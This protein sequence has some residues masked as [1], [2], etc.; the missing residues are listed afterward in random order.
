MQFIIS[1]SHLPA[2]RRIIIHA[3][4]SWPFAKKMIIPGIGERC[5][6]GLNRFSPFSLVPYSF[7][8]QFHH[9]GAM[10][11]FD[12]G[13]DGRAFTDCKAIAAETSQS[14]PSLLFRLVCLQ[15]RRRLHRLDFSPFLLALSVQHIKNE[16]ARLMMTTLRKRHASH[17]ER[18]VGSSQ[19]VNKPT[20]VASDISSKCLLI[21]VVSSWAQ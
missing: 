4:P 1:L 10:I 6:R 7:V 20:L 21:R 5:C 18:N 13:L 8:P 16:E 14:P 9:H 12:W 19:L 17:H 3:C 15:Y 11:P 2:D